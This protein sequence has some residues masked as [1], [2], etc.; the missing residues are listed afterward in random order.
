MINLTTDCVLLK[1]NDILGKKLALMTDKCEYKNG[2]A[3]FVKLM[4]WYNDLKERVEV[5]CFGIKTAKNCSSD[6]AL[7]INHNLKLFEYT[8]DAYS[9]L[10]NMSLTDV[11]VVISLVTE[12]TECNRAINN[13]DYLWG[14]S[15]HTI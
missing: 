12:L 8:G 5:V 13:M 15:T 11:G 6:A 1:N 2:A 9:L 4:A 3:S 14:T 10:F 7:G